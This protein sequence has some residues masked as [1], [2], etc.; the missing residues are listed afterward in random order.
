MR[1][2]SL[3]ISQSLTIQIVGWSGRWDTRIDRATATPRGLPP[4]APRG[5]DRGGLA[6]EPAAAGAPGTPGRRLVRRMGRRG[7]RERD[8]AGRAGTSSGVP[9]RFSYRPARGERVPA[10]RVHDVD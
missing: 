2:A 8:V 1:G 4:R 5:G 7:D 9:W 3:D 6:G 10:L